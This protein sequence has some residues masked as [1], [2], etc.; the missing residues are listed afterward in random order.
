MKDVTDSRPFDHLE[1]TF[2]ELGRLIF[3]PPTH[4]ARRWQF[5]VVPTECIVFGRCVFWPYLRRHRSFGLDR[6]LAAMAVK[7]ATP[8]AVPMARP[9]AS[10]T[11]WPV[12]RLKPVWAR[13]G[14]LAP[15]GAL[16]IALML[17]AD[18]T[19]WRPGAIPTDGL[20][21]GVTDDLDAA[22][23]TLKSHS[24]SSTPGQPRRVWSSTVP[25]P[26]SQNKPPK[27]ARPEPGITARRPALTAGNLRAIE[28]RNEIAQRAV[29]TRRTTRSIQR[30]APA[31]EARLV[32]TR[33]TPFKRRRER[34]S[35]RT[36]TPI[37]AGLPP[38]LHHEAGLP[39]L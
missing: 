20:T 22:P 23:A 17:S 13:W 27:H 4:K 25:S 7:R 30:M 5:S 2:P 19:A 9:E 3:A 34:I 37:E 33:Q 32:E 38:A 12:R 10:Q 16:F 28:Q 14:A 18:W 8:V 26:R 1:S 24:T 11:V 21:S 36:T 35:S 31:S 15:A 29:P 39:P 6:S